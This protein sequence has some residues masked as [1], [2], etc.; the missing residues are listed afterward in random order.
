[1]PVQ[2]SE[3]KTEFNT[4]SPRLYFRALNNLNYI[5]KI[6]FRCVCDGYDGEDGDDS[7]L[8]SRGRQC[9]VRKA[10]LH[11]YCKVFLT[12]YYKVF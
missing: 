2:V 3:V 9:R 8:G 11:N 1:L 4:F 10:G 12:R 5:N 7:G 6:P